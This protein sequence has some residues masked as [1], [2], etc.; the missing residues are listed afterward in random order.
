MRYL[1]TNGRP[2]DSEEDELTATLTFLLTP[3]FRRIYHPW[4]KV[5][6]EQVGE[7]SYRL[8]FRVKKGYNTPF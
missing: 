1:L 4:H 6:R 8:T 3:V 2:E 5:I 7:V